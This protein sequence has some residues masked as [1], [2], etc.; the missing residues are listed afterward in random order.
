[1]T[2]SL[3]KLQKTLLVQN[4]YLLINHSEWAKSQKNQSEEVR[5]C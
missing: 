2:I 3:E 4:M 5:F 1:M